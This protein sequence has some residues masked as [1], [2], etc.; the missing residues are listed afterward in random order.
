MTSNEMTNQDFSKDTSG[1]ECFERTYE[2]KTKKAEFL[3]RNKD[4]I[5]RK[6]VIGITIPNELLEGDEKKFDTPNSLFAIKAI[7]VKL[8]DL[9]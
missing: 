7:E 2:A 1:R 4:R 5:N 9:N 8:K 3:G 6:T